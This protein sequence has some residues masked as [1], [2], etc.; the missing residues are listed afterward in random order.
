M[1]T[2][3]PEYDVIVI[4]SGAAG[5]WVAKET[6]ERGCRTLML[7][8]G[9]ALDPKDDFPDSDRAGGSRVSILSRVMAILRGQHVQ[10]RCMSFTPL[11]GHLFVNDRQNPYTTPRDGHFN[12]FRSR[13]VGGRLHLWGRNALRLSDQEFKAADQDGFGDSWPISYAD[14]DPWYGRVEQFLGVAGEAAQIENLPD[15]LYDAPHPLT[16]AERNLMDELAQKWPDR[17]ATTCRII[18]HV[19]ARTPLPL[20]A[21]QA[22]G[23]F[24]L[25]SG[26]VVSKIETNA[27][28]GLATGVRYI[29]ASSGH[30]HSVTARVIAV[31]ASTIESVRLLLNS[32]GPRHAQGLGNSSGNL[33]RYLSDHLMVFRAGTLPQVEGLGPSHDPYDFGAQSGIYIPGFRNRGGPDDCG[34]LRSYSLLGSVGRI[35]PGWFFM[36]IGEVLPRAENRIELDANRRDAWGIPVPKVTLRHSENERAMVQDMKDTLKDVSETFGL[37]DDLLGRESLISKLAYKMA[38]PLVYTPD[39]ALQPGSSIHETG[40]ACMGDDPNRH[41]LNRDLE[42]YDCPNVHVTDSAAFP[43]NPFQNPGLT[44][45]ALSARAGARIAEK[46]TAE[47]GHGL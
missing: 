42:V 19:P 26:A 36:A 3:G 32:H 47:K 11:T 29:D 16:G 33:G 17:P 7:E 30:E 22:S 6:S 34:F 5:G 1:Q 4:G 10:A 35:E 28:T 40:G 20:T 15:G 44:I 31:C 27:K 43:T 46:V 24:E 21:A 8:A 23:N 14:L 2:P 12:W 9:R 41:V 25:R 39:G 45:M 37:P 18:R 13:Q 38:G